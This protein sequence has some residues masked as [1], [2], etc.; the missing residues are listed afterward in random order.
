MHCK[1]RLKMKQKLPENIITRRITTLSRRRFIKGV[2]I[3]GIASRI[4]F[5]VSCTTGEKPAG[6][7]LNQGQKDTMAAVQQ[8]LFPDDGNGPGAK[9]I[10]ALEYLLWV[11]DD[12][13]M[14]KDDKAFII[15]G[16]EWI[17]EEAEKEYS[18]NFAALEERKQKK[19]IVKISALDKGELWLST[20]MTFILEALLSNPLYG[21]NP[22]EKGWKWLHHY[23]GHPQPGKD[24]IY[25]EIITTIENNL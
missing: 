3:A 16:I 10:N 22:E 13:R 18:E 19:L 12:E 1:A 6:V 15:N 23:A 17:N 8:I 7:K 14:D 9:E 20:I 2:A 24:L 11:L 21:G 5:W 25:P 4:P